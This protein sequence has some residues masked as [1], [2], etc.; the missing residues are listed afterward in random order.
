MKTN[1]FFTHPY[2]S[3]EK[4][5][6]EYTNKLVWQYI[7]EKTNFESINPQQIK[8]IQYKLNNRPRKNLK[9]QT[10]KEVFFLNLQI[11]KKLHSLVESTV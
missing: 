8:E 4:G 7:P 1:F 9:F 6:I 5:L 10:P 2:T 11:L 3:W